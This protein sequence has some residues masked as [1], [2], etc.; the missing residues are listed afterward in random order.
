MGIP[1]DSIF[2]VGFYIGSGKP[3]HTHNGF[4][5]FGKKKFFSQAQKHHEKIFPLTA[6][7]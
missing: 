4:Q 5:N 6:F 3:P 2:Y 7:L 1:I